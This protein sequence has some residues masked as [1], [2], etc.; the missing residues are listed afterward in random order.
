MQHASKFRHLRSIH[1]EF[2]LPWRE[3]KY[4]L[5][6]LVTEE[7]HNPLK[8]NVRPSMMPL[9]PLAGG[10]HPHFCAPIKAYSNCLCKML[11]HHGTK[12][13]YD[14]SKVGEKGNQVHARGH[15]YPRSAGRTQDLSMLA[16]RYFGSIKPHLHTCGHQFTVPFFP[17][18]IDNPIF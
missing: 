12:Q 5:L 8:Q 18:S 16:E 2:F 15:C 13:Q 6:H 1:H 4:F 7:I 11:I 10:L 14:T 9:P 17:V 3:P